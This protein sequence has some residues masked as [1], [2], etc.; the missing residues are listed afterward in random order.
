MMGYRR[1]A[2]KLYYQLSL[3]RLVPQNHLP[4]GSYGL[5]A[6]LQIFTG[7]CPWAFRHGSRWQVFS[8]P[9]ALTKGPTRKPR[10][11]GLLKSGG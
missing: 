9:G 5:M 10:R 3:E 1:F 6:S 11:K 4:A 8:S 2:P 7:N